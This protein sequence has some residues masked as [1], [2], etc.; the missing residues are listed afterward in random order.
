MKNPQ[1]REH[2]GEQTGSIKTKYHPCIHYTSGKPISSSMHVSCCDHKYLTV[3]FNYY[4]LN[5]MGFLCVCVFSFFALEENACLILWNIPLLLLH[6]HLSLLRKQCAITSQPGT[7]HA[8]GRRIITKETTQ[9]KP[10]NLQACL[11]TVCTVHIPYLAVDMQ[12]FGWIRNVRAL[13]SLFYC[14]W[15]KKAAGF[16]FVQSLLHSLIINY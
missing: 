15:S 16:M 1:L 6:F 13:P 2:F 10:G 11:S 8:I 9:W 14:D 5:K 12:H 3:Y 4:N 7:P